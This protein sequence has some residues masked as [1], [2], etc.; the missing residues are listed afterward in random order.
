MT[1]IEPKIEQY[2]TGR[3]VLLAAVAALGGFLFGFDTAVINGAVLAI[4]ETFRMGAGL[5]GFV[6]ASAL[7][8]CAVGAWLAG[9][10]ADQIGRIKVM[11][12]AAVLFFVSAIGSG[13][14]YSPY[15]LTFWRI[16][17][18]LGV[19]AASVIA[20]AYIAEIAPASIRG[21]LGSLL[22]LAI[23]SGIF[24]ALLSD[25]FLATT[26]GGTNYDLWFGLAAWR[27]MF[28]SLAVPALAYGILVLQI[29]E[30]PRYLMF[31]GRTIEAR[32]V[33]S[34][35]LKSGVDNRIQEISRT[36]VPDVQSTFRDLRGPVFGLLPIVW[37][38]IL[39]SVFQQFV[40]I[41]VIFYYSSTLWQQV[42]FTEADSLIIT[43]LTSVTNIVVTLAAIA[44]IDKIGRRLLLLIGSAGMFVSLAALAYVFGTAP[45]VNGQPT[46]SDTAGAIA[47]I[48][49]N[50]FVVFFGLSWGPTVWVLLGEMFNNRIRA[51]ALGLAVSAQWISNFVISTSF[52]ALA[53]ISL[54]LA[55]GLYTIFA[56][57]SLLFAAK[58]VPETK[59]KQLEDMG[60]QTDLDQTLTASKAAAVATP[61]DHPGHSF[62]RPSAWR[63]FADGVGS[64]FTV[65]NI[66]GISRYRSQ[67][68]AWENLEQ[69]LAEKYAQLEEGGIPDGSTPSNSNDRRTGR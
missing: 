28:L 66:T 69:R 61:R 49:A 39:L 51:A 2:D 6:V 57:L 67:P 16:I 7:L 65:A 53:D 62:V 37:A 34:Q 14:A 59:G 1:S 4:R 54:G 45:V 68:S 25:Y 42:G 11:V 24:V 9:K 27:W 48:A 41:N 33:L 60:Q 22:Q 63:A 36:I 10:L 47:L 58:F 21:R 46:L 3:A 55:Y 64:V 12:L 29:A 20:P 32:A 8:G 18:G 38:G 23:V 35:V 56:L 40:G 15:D 52:P 31:R 17:G 5:T 43:V 26:A 30:S 13:L 19:G 50:A 44:V